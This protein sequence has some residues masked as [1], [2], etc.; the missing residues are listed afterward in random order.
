MISEKIDF[1]V[2]MSDNEWGQY[3]FSRDPINKKI[4]C[5]LR[6]EMIEKANSCGREQA[7]KIKKTYDNFQIIYVHSNNNIQQ[8][9]PQEVSR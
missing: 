1:L 2:S 3:A 6:Q 5:E 7:L 8:Y 9:L 4:S